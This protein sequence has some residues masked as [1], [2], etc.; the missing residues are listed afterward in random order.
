LE[1]LNK[2]PEEWFEANLTV[3]RQE[4]SRLIT[5]RENARKIK[6]S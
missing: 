3:D 2:S 1:I 6:I 5:E 4:L